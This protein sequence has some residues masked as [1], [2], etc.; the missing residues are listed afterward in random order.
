MGS[1]TN[2]NSTAVNITDGN[3]ETGTV[4][5][6]FSLCDLV[7]KVRDVDL[8]PFWPFP[9]KITVP[10][11]SWLSRLSFTRNIDA[12]GTNDSGLL[13]SNSR[14]IIS[15]NGLNN[16]SS[17]VIPSQSELN[18]PTAIDQENEMNTDIAGNDVVV[19][20]DVNCVR[21]Q[22]DDQ[23]DNAVVEN[24]DVNGERSQNDD[25]R[26]NVVVEN[27]E[28]NCEGSQQDDQRGNTVVE[29][30]DVNRERSQQDD[31]RVNAVVENENVNC[32]RSQND[33]Q[34][35]NNALVVNEDVNCERSQNDD[36]TG[37]NALVVNEDVNC[38]RPQQDDQRV[39]RTYALR[40][41]KAHP[42]P[43]KTYALRNKSKK[44]SL[45]ESVGN[46]RAETPN[47]EQV[48]V[49]EVA[50]SV[51]DTLS[52]E[53]DLSRCLFI[54]GA[55]SKRPRSRVRTRRLADL[56]GISRKEPLIGGKRKSP[57]ESSKVSTAGEASGNASKRVDSGHVGTDEPNESGFDIGSIK[58]KK[59]NV[60]FQVDDEL[61]DTEPEV[62]D[63][64]DEDPSY[65]PRAKRSKNVKK[66]KTKRATKAIDPS[67]KASSSVQPSL[68]E[69]E[70]VPSPPREQRTEERVG[71]SLDD[72]LASEGYVREANAPPVNDGQE[73][74]RT[75]S[76]YVPVF[77]NPSVPGRGLGTGPG[78]IYFGS[79]SNNNQRN[80][81][82]TEVAAQST[83]PQKDA[84]IPN[85]GRGLGTGPGAIYLGSSSSNN[86]NN[87]RNT[88]PTEVAAQ[89]TV[90]Q[91][92]AS[93][94]NAGRGLGT[95]PG[96]IYF[97]S[98][99]SNNNN[100][101]STPP[102]TVEAAQPSV[103]QKDAPIPNTG[104]GLG[105]GPGAIY[106]GS[107]NNNNNNL[108]STPPSTQVAA[109]SSVPQKDASVSDRKGKGVMIQSHDET[110]NTQ[111]DISNN[112]PQE[113]PQQPK[114][115]FL[116]DLNEIYEDVTS[117][118]EN[119]N[120]A[121]EEDLVPVRSE[122][123][124]SVESLPPRPSS[125][126]MP[127]PVQESR[128]SSILFP[129]H[130]T[131]WMGNVPM[132]SPYHHPS[133][134]TYQVI[135]VHPQFRAPS[136]PVWA[137]S[138][139]PPQYHHHHH[140]P[141][142]PFNMDYSS[143]FAQAPSNDTWNLSYLGANLMNQAMMSRMDPRFRS[144]T[145]VNHHGNIYFTPGNVHPVNQFNQIV[146]LQRSHERQVFP[147]TI[148]NQG[149]FQQRR[150]VGSSS[151]T[152]ASPAG[153][154][155]DSSTCIISR[156]PGEITE[157]EP[158]MVAEEDLHVPERMVEFEQAEDQVG[159]VTESG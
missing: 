32:E 120:A 19:N 23:R 158:Y 109:Q 89:S 102:S 25:H 96:A 136:P 9:M 15:T 75:R 115:P 2:L 61:D 133:S 11:N 7:A 34:T 122:R 119:T 47:V 149:R 148:S 18:S 118:E 28:V 99:S 154:S 77:G 81:S 139:M 97:G 43:Y 46:K 121:R 59:K 94:P 113:V 144:N 151:I 150:N 45:A 13:P 100:L 104:R 37:N 156:Y 10:N 134:S 67:N 48:A 140:S 55:P 60:R 152:Y 54:G 65:P 52:E 87:Q 42:Q 6:R 107:S 137:S 5:D 53:S 30:E 86:N 57:P 117:L 17:S 106:F 49:P 8:K 155:S 80:T 126:V 153:N 135:H 111:N 58:G 103:P 27:E 68:N 147:R 35:G 51:E 116:F 108:R 26:D 92:D 14:S 83:V 146:E 33:D 88:T 64:S 29:N 78:A 93:I 123:Q 142:A 76:S 56:S 128:R 36:Q 105:T 127:P 130:N 129:G 16:G 73:N 112:L 39:T 22:N 132:D 38:E 125:S 71:T 141:P 44:N 101:R 95:G 50:A 70:T 145:P 63:E 1:S 69:N 98:S 3:N 31:Q 91:K 12:N 40:N 114:T 72:E 74:N 90:P 4:R 124:N 84:S 82:S 110:E 20:E 85:T 131:Q 79:S 62:D 159:P 24:E 143:M 157:I 66:A 41:K 138:M 21:S